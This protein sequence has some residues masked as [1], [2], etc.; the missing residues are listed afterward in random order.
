MI[1]VCDG[2]CKKGTV[3]CAHVEVSS[4]SQ[5]DGGLGIAHTSVHI[6]QSQAEEFQ[7]ED[8]FDPQKSCDEYERLLIERLRSYLRPQSAPA[9]LIERLHSMFER[10][11]GL[12][13]TESI[14]EITER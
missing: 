12:E 13:E 4:C 3:M 6:H 2:V 10:L 8:C 11:E 14:R 1:K 5:F 9:C 7:E